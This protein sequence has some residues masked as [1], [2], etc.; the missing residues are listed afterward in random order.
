MPACRKECGHYEAIWGGLRCW[1][2]EACSALH[3][4]LDLLSHPAMPVLLWTTAGVG[5]LTVTAIF[6]VGRLRGGSEDDQPAASSMLTN[7]RELHSRGG[8]SDQEFRTIKTLL[9]DRIQRELKDSGDK[10]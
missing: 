5:L 10:G 6:V 8:L 1:R 4:V 7:F 2:L 3:A 9:A